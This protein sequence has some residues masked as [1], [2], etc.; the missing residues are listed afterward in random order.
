MEKGGA[1]Y[2]NLLNWILR[3]QN[4]KREMLQSSLSIE[5]NGAL[6]SQKDDALSNT[7]SR[8]PRVMV[9][10]IKNQILPS[11]IGGDTFVCNEQQ[12]K[13]HSPNF[14]GQDYE[15]QRQYLGLC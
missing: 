7:N 3:A 6:P 12:P 10:H 5:K 1:A 4:L 9:R 2:Q 15:K 13:H 11:L 8:N 14:R